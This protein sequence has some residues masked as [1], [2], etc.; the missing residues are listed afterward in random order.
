M[1][2]NFARKE[3]NCDKPFFLWNGKQVFFQMLYSDKCVAK[4]KE[5]QFELRIF[6]AMSAHIRIKT[7]GI[8]QIFFACRILYSYLSRGI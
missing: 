1:N 6:L 5:V 4:K 8:N 2:F 7:L 3:K